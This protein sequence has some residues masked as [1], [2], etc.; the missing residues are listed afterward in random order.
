MLVC[1]FLIHNYESNRFRLLVD[2]TDFNVIKVLGHPDVC[3][4]KLCFATHLLLLFLF[5]DTFNIRRH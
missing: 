2:Y 5:R 1:I 4:E 3:Y